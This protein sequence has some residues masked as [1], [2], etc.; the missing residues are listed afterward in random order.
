MNYAIRYRWC[1]T[2]APHENTYL[3]NCFCCVSVFISRILMESS[4]SFPQYLHDCFNDND[5][6][7][8]SKLAL[9]DVDK[10]NCHLNK[11]N[12]TSLNRTQ[13]RLYLR[14]NDV[15]KWKHYSRHW[16]FVRGIHRPPV[17]SLTR[18]S[19][20]ELWCFLWSV[21]EQ[22]VEQAIETPVIW[23]VIALIM[24]SLYDVLLT[25]LFKY[26]TQG[27]FFLLSYVIQERSIS[28]LIASTGRF[29]DFS[30]YN[31]F[32]VQNK[33]AIWRSIN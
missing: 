12:M 22:T 23:D 5:C 8:A 33:R 9:K 13:I 11:Q 20:A 29:R 15:V 21:P 25:Y 1:T 30:L 17:V 10:I 31:H 6:P 16:P 14:H 18:T 32:G 28:Q 7:S 4:Y 2:N 24:T 26:R 3:H 27:Y 19:D